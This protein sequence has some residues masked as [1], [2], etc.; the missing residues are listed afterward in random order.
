M[1]SQGR[2]LRFVKVL[3]NVYFWIK[4]VKNMKC[5]RD[6]QDFTFHAA[7]LQCLRVGQNFLIEQ[8]QR[9]NSHPGRWKPG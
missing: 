3:N 5:A 7:A 2:Y 4:L 1:G 6:N 8:I 9:A